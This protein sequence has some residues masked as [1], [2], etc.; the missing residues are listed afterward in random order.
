MILESSNQL[1]ETLEEWNEN[2]GVPPKCT[3]GSLIQLNPRKYRAAHQ[4]WCETG[5]LPAP[6]RRGRQCVRQVAN[7]QSID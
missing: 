6:A 7:D 2:R 3:R 4:S 1:V 5:E